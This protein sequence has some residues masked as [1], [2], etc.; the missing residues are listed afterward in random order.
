MFY[1]TCC[2]LN[3]YEKHQVVEKQDNNNKA[4]YGKE[5]LQKFSQE[6]TSE[7][8]NGFSHA[9]LRKYTHQ[10]GLEIFP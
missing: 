10:E 4:S 9:N 3:V 5:I 2:S 7:L 1:L 6:L 8:G